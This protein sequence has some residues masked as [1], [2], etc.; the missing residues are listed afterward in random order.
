LPL[1]QQKEITAALRVCKV[2]VLQ[3]VFFYITKNN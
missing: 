1:E 3:L 2:R